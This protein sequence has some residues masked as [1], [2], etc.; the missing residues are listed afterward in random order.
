MNKKFKLT[1]E[2]VEQ[3]GVKLYRIESIKDFSNVR[4][5]DKGGFVEKEEN[6]SEEGDAWV[7][8]DARVSGDAQ[9]S[10]NARVYGDA[11]VS[12]DA[13]VSGNAQVYKQK[14]IGGYFYHTKQKSEKIESVE[15]YDDGY[16]TLCREPKFD[17][18]PEEVSLKGKVVKV[19]LDGKSYSAIIQ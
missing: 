2:S 8:G 4:K 1:K 14:L 12:G 10:G 16:E 6:I 9:V 19:E 7:S 11:R 18:E 13:W 5:G 17:K 15:T 3:W